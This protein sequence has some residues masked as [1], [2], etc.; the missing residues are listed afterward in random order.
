MTAIAFKR[1]IQDLTLN[2]KEVMR[3]YFAYWSYQLAFSLKV[4]IDSQCQN[5]TWEIQV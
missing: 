5:R 3:P 1:K 4:S 2:E